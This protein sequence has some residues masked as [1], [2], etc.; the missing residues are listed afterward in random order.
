MSKEP[1]S[2]PPDTP[3]KGLTASTEPPPPPYTPTPSATNPGFC[4]LAFSERHANRT[5]GGG[6]TA[7]QYFAPCA[8]CGT[9]ISDTIP[10]IYKEGWKWVDP[11][12][13]FR[14]ESHLPPNS[15][16]AT[17]STVPSTTPGKQPEMSE[18]GRS[19][20]AAALSSERG[21]LDYDVD[22]EKG[23]G[24]QGGNERLSCWICWEY[25]EKFVG[26][27]GVDEWYVHLRGHFRD[28]G[29]RICR[30]KTGGMQRRRNCVVKGCPKIHS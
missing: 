30:G 21:K 16:M 27:M 10:G 8:L 5:P 2:S 24:S 28:E 25:E 29:F 22:L 1:P 26:G 17:Y 3:S 7:A 19:L 14:W 9:Q 11:S 6:L 18:V 15:A 23:E 20:A 4:P 13:N 12:V